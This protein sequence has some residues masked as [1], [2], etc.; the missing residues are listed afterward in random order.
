MTVS[1]K[2]FFALFPYAVPRDLVQA[3][4]KSFTLEGAVGFL[5]EAR[6]RL[7]KQARADARQSALESLSKSSV[8][9]HG[10]RPTWRTASLSKCMSGQDEKIDKIDSIFESKIAELTKKPESQQPASVEKWLSKQ[11][12]KT[13]QK[14]AATPAAVSSFQQIDISFPEAITEQTALSLL[15]AMKMK[16]EEKGAEVA[17]AKRIVKSVFFSIIGKNLPEA[18]LRGIQRVFDVPEMIAAMK[19]ARVAIPSDITRRNVGMLLRSIDDR[20]D[21][22]DEAAIQLEM[23]VKPVVDLL[24]EVPFCPVH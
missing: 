7:V 1:L 5:N 9:G 4:N 24:L 16:F 17:V 23:I 3:C 22:E 15:D 21:E 10:K 6:D 12:I 8:T 11:L 2:G 14:L 13:F 18:T 19:C 20:C